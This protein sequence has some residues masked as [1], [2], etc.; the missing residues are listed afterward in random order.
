MS[1]SKS[2]MYLQLIE[3][4]E[5]SLEIETDK[6]KIKMYRDLIE[7]YKLALELEEDSQPKKQKIS[8]ENKAQIKQLIKSI[9]KST[10]QEYGDG[11]LPYELLVYAND[12]EFEVSEF[13]SFKNITELDKVI[14]KIITKHKNKLLRI[15][16]RWSQYYGYPD[17]IEIYNAQELEGEEI[18]EEIK[19]E[20]IKINAKKEVIVEEPIQE[21]I[22][23][24]VAKNDFRPTYLMTLDEYREKVTPLIQA[25]KK[26]LRKNKDWF[27]KPEYSGIAHYSFEEALEQID[28]EDSAFAPTTK[29]STYKNKKE[30]EKSI[31][32][33]YS[34]KKTRK[35]DDKYTQEPTPPNL[36]AENKEYIEKLKK[37]FSTDD[38]NS[39]VDDDETKSNKRAVRRAIDNDIYKEL[40][41]NKKVQLIE[42]QKVADS[43]GIRL[44]KSIFDKS[45]QNQMKYEEELGKLL[46]NIPI[47]SF[48]KLKE[49]IK[50]IKVDLIPLEE[51]VYEQEY[52][53]YTEL[54]K[55]N[56]GTTKKAESFGVVIPVWSLIYNYESE[57]RK[58]NTAYKNW[59]GEYYTESVEYVKLNKLKSDWEKQL[60][61]YLK[62]YVANLKNS[63]II[64]IM[65]N[66]QSINMPIKSIERLTIEVGKKGFEGS[67]KFTFE[68]GSSFIMNFQGVGAGG[69]NIQSY[70]FR[71][72]TNFSNVKLADGSKGG[73]NYYEIAD[74]FSTKR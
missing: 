42:L 7:G 46:S 22:S 35:H 29:Y 12:D 10:Y 61:N 62:E 31:R 52:A 50:Q 14:D 48:E 2:N 27:V 63:I 19:T 65:R 60:E 17:S 59:K 25:Y 38:L 72:L 69:Y 24:E 20:P 8:A 21:V 32:E 5:L 40:L 36:I 26:F 33:N 56:I 44:P 9:P 3:G 30:K 49:L 53:R 37:Y 67:Y 15:E 57:Y 54:I 4:Y 45:T 13:V 47:L 16:F 41:T 51:L 6:N 58:E 34:Y 70:H 39:R 28:D 66:F 1:E 74:K 18:Q 64:A 71:Y 11:G 43:V 68:N 23:E 55:K 73:T